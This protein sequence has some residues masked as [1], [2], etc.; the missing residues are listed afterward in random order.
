MRLATRAAVLTAIVG[1]CLF[2]LAGVASAS[3]NPVGSPA[4][5]KHHPHSALAACQ[6][7]GSGGPPPPPPT[8]TVTVSPNGSSSLVETGQSEV[9][10]VVEAET[11]PA[12][13][14]DIVDINSQQL[15]NSCGGT[16][17]F[18]SLQPTASYTA[19]SVDVTLD[20]DGNATVDLYGLDCAPGADLI[21]AD[22]VAAPYYTAIGTVTVG[23]PNVT[24]PG[25][26]GFP[27][28]EVETGNTVPSGTSDAYAVFYVET[29]PVYAEQPVTIDSPQLFDRCLGGIAWIS[30][31]NSSSTFSLTGTLDNDGNAVFVFTG[32]ECA[33]G[34]STVIADID[35]GIHSSYSTTYTI[36]APTPTI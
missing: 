20:A 30:G 8:I 22:L 18:G 21:E 6:G 23:P 13:S 32:A 7:G 17:L 4:W 12:F 3:T 10:A 29:D 35:A 25:I 34:S 9:H 19:D 33:P 27:A 15:A 14:D 36:D 24:P 16:I 31:P 28:D 26:T 1:L 11:S 5:C 2:G